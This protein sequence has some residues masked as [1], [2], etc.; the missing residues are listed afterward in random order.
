MWS[1]C[2]LYVVSMWS[3]C[4]QYVASMWSVCGQ[5]VVSVW[6]V[7]GQYVV[8]MWPVCGQY[9]VSMWSVCG[10]AGRVINIP[11][12]SRLPPNETKV[13][14]GTSQSKSGTSVNL[15]NSGNAVL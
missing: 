4:G 13:E 14:I 3:V 5:Y 7:C 12:A 8:S 6:S 10:H 9:V 2:G 11:F 1:V 15:S